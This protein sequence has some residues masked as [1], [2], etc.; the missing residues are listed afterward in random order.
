[1]SCVVTYRCPSAGCAQM[2]G[3]WVER[4]GPFTFSSL[5][6]CLTSARA[7]GPGMYVYCNCSAPQPVAPVK[8]P[9]EVAADQAAAQAKQADDDGMAAY[10][11]GGLDAASVLFMKAAQLEPGNALYHQHLVMVHVD[12]DSKGGAAAINAMSTELDSTAAAGKIDSFA[13]DFDGRGRRPADDALP[14]VDNRQLVALMRPARMVSFPVLP[15]PVPVDQPV[16]KTLTSHQKEIAAVDARL[17]ETELA[18]KRLMAQNNENQQQLDE[19][20]ESSEEASNDAA[21]LGVSLVLDLMDADVD[22]L[23]KVNDESRDVALNAVI[24]QGKDAATAEQTLNKLVQ[25]RKSL[26]RA[27]EESRLAGKLETLREKIEDLHEPMKDPYFSREDILDMEM[28]AVKPIEEAMGPSRDLVDACYT[29]FKQAVSLDHM[30]AVEQD[31]E[32]SLRAT[33]ALR[34]TLKR[35][36]EQ[37]RMLAKQAPPVRPEK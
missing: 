22:D 28:P 21:R 18:L 6:Q 15:E 1:M 8:T 11:R 31:Q 29:I 23:A 24:N 19:W 32:Q 37:R 35:L 34:R 17:A 16:G 4:R 33:Q 30:A 5:A 20:T 13:A 3:T 9:E 36:V 26:E 2:M 7:A 10:N 14:V 12:Q 25:V 27:H